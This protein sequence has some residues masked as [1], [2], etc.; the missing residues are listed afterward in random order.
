MPDRPL[1]L[2]AWAVRAI[3]DGRKTRHSVILKPQP[4]P[5]LSWADPPAGCYPSSKGW[6]RFPF[7]VG[8]RLWVR[9]A[10]ATDRSM[11]SYRPATMAQNCRDAGYDEIWAPILYFADDVVHNRVNGGVFGRQRHALH[12]PRWASRI[13]LTV[14]GMA[15]QRVQDITEA[16]AVAEG[17]DAAQ[18]RMYPEL[19]TCRDWFQDFWN[20]THGPGA[21][22]RNDWVAAATFTAR[23]RNID[24]APE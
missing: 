9:E 7:A 19:G 13:T 16:A 2:P 8:D 15:V 14:T 10:W 22:D 18:A 4:V 12:M 5:S 6:S 3:R 20:S 24:E 23:M 17:A 11:D 21:W 1:S